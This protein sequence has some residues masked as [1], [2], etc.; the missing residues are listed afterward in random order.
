MID[1]K[2]MI[3]AILM[4]DDAMTGIVDDMG[5]ES[6]CAPGSMVLMSRLAKQFYRRGDEQLLG[7]SSQTVDSDGD[8]L[9]DGP[10]WLA[11]PIG[12]LNPVLYTQPTVQDAFGD[13]DRDGLINA[14]ELRDHTN[15]GV[16]DIANLVANAARYQIAVEPV[17]STGGQQ[18]YSLN[19]QNVLLVPTLDTGNGPGLN[20]IILS[21]A[22]VAEDDV[23]MAPIFRIVE[24]TA[25]YPIGGI[26][27]PPDGIL[28]VQP[29]DFV[30]KR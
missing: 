9:P 5:Q 6:G 23:Q 27:D 22:Q 19:I 14:I 28:V 24:L 26:K 30:F 4:T 8:G 18:C 3:A 10:E 20:H 7:M 25:R 17:P 15:P 29:S 12:S 21:I 2:F 16:A 13:P 11:N 1:E